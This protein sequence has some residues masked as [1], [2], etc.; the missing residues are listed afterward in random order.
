MTSIWLPPTSTTGIRT[1]G[2]SFGRS[3]SLH[4]AVPVEPGAVIRWR[5]A[6]L[7]V[8]TVEGA[9]Q[10]M[11]S[12]KDTS[13][14]SSPWTLMETNCCGLRVNRGEETQTRNRW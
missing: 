6:G 5:G 12:K 10:C 7:G 11:E 4:T 1:G 3:G 8:G 2:A 9:L 13:K 14:T